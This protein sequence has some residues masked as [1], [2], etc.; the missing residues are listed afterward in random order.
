MHEIPNLP[1][2]SLHETEQQA[3]QQASPQQPEAKEAKPVDGK[4]PD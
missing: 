2:P 1:F 3:P 4:R